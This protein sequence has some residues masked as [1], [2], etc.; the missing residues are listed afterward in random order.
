MERIKIASHRKRKTFS[1][2]TQ[3]N[4]E[5]V[6]LYLFRCLAVEINCDKQIQNVRN[7][8]GQVRMRISVDGEGGRDGLEQD[9]GE[10]QSDTD[11]QVKSHTSFPFL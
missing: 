3:Y 4:W 1:Q 6:F 7:P 9:V 2:L 11:S 8:H 10:T 5:N